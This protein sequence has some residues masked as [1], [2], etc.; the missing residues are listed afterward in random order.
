MV[1][2]WIALFLGFSGYIMR[3]ID[4]SPPPFVI[5]FILGGNLEAPARR[6]FA[7]TGADPPFPFNCP[8]VVAFMA[9]VAG[10]VV[11]GIGKPAT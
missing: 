3:R 6:A 7:A 2:V 4:M 5:T 11:H 8:V 9:M 10:V 1:A